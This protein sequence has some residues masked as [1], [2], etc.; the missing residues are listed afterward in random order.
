MFGTQWWLYVR[1][2]IA[3]DPARLF[4]ALTDAH[5]RA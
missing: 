5:R 4:Q 3:E 1:N 2:R